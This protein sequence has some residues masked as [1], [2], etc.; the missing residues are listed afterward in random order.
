[1]ATKPPTPTESRIKPT[2][3][4]RDVT[5][6]IFPVSDKVKIRLLSLASILTVL[7]AIAVL[8]RYCNAA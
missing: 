5:G 4:R 7:G 3:S 8:S 6:C 2:V 1:M